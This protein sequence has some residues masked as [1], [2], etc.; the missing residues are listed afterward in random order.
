KRAVVAA[1]QRYD[2]TGAAEALQT[3]ADPLFARHCPAIWKRLFL[4]G[5]FYRDVA[6][7][8]LGFVSVHLDVC[9]SA[10]QRR[11]AID[12]FFDVEVVPAARVVDTLAALL[13]QRM[14]PSVASDAQQDDASVTTKQCVR[15]LERAIRDGGA[16]DQIVA[17]M[18]KLEDA[19]PG[20]RSLVAFQAL[21]SHLGSLPDLVHNR[22]QRETP[23]CFKPRH[24]F[25]RLSDSL[26]RGLVQHYAGADAARLPA[27]SL[28]FRMVCEKL[29]RIGQTSALLQSWLSSSDSA[30]YDQRAEA[31]HHLLLR[32]LPESCHEHVLLELGRVAAACDVSIQSD[33]RD[34]RSP[35]YRL[36]SL[37][38]ATV[39]ANKQFQYV[40]AHKLLLR[41]PFEDLYFLRA[42]VDVLARADSGRDVAAAELSKPTAMAP[43]PAVFDIVVNRWSQPDFAGAADYELNASMSFFLRY[44]FKLLASMP[45]FSQTD[46]VPKLCRGVQAHMSHSL[47]RT[48]LLGMRVGESLSLVISPEQP[49]SFEIRAQDPLEV[50]GSAAFDGGA[51]VVERSAEALATAARGVGAGRIGGASPTAGAKKRPTAM[52][53]KTAVFALD[54]D[55]VLDS[56]AA[57]D[58]DDGDGTASGNDDGGDDSDSDASL[59]AYDLNDDEQDLSAK[60]PLYLKDLVA[61]LQADEDREKV[62]AALSEAEALLRKR[63][64]DL[65]EQ[66][67]E[68]VTALLRLEDKFNTPN[69]E[70]LRASSLAAAC[71]VAPLKVVPYFQRQALER[72]QLLQSRIDVLQAMMAA[73]QELAQVGDFRV[74]APKSLLSED[75]EA[76]TTRELKTRRWGYRRDPLAQPKRNAFGEHALG[77]FSPLLFGYVEYVRVHAA[78]PPSASSPAGS[79]GLSEIESTFLAHLL[80]ALG[81]FVECAGS[82]PQAIP[83]AK[84]LLEFA[85]RERTSSVAAVRRQVLF[86]VSRAL[87]VV[88]PFMLRQDMGEQVAALAGWLQ[89]VVRQDPDA[90]CREGSR[91]LLSS[92]MMPLVSLS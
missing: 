5:G 65:H 86:S 11:D 6:A 50:F 2:V 34:V 25:A 45:A 7:F 67:T 63:P 42:L 62:E 64:R 13:V 41:K 59:E 18:L 77:F 51:A 49:L 69:F 44:A 87:V 84:C 85:W 79:G 90:G 70:A 40:V 35:K 32:S 76:R 46:W 52:K 15:Q 12:V 1:E 73:S 68:V 74:A 39:A 83:M 92:G 16:L 22:C 9:F 57:S 91:L 38:P 4:D 58:D 80:H 8:V 43:L 89:R 55:G 72:E 88:P 61:G 78:P 66:A 71:A 54:P 10:A 27:A 23:S 33:P 28:V 20:G 36:V 30:L 53:K 19:V 82:S 29:I 26:V 21:V 48:R 75:L 14:P 24:Y 81:V 17:V 31:T 60:R 56:D 3:L 37:I 47:E